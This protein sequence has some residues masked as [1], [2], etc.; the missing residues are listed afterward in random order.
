MGRVLPTYERPEDITWRHHLKYQ[1]VAGSVMCDSRPTQALLR[2]EL[3]MYPL[4]TT[5]E[6]GI[7]NGPYGVKNMRRKK[8]L[9]IVDGTVRKKM[10]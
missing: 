6:K 3:R 9:S 4:T 5:G 10:E 7:L 8:V 1:T 2:A